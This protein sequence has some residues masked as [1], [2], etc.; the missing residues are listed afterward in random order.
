MRGFK[1][2]G[3]GVLLAHEDDEQHCTRHGG[4]E[5]G[6][7]P[8]HHAADHPLLHPHTRARTHAHSV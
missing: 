2:C 5:V 7:P 6:E 4:M 1:P 8:V 3:G